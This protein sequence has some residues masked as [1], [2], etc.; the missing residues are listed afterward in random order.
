M[1]MSIL[2][3]SK[4]RHSMLGLVLLF[5]IA[6][7]TTPDELELLDK[8]FTAYERALRWQDYDLIISFHKNER[9]KLTVEKRKY[10]KRF[11]VTGYNVV[12]S[13]VEPGNTKANQV[14]EIKYYDENYATVR[15]LTISNKWEYDEN[16][17]HW[18]LTNDLP[19]FK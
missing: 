9:E 14:I 11:R 16:I 17:K 18:Q 7:A 4:I 1:P 3:L 5:P 8:S 6:C 12:Y 13:S 19:D 2:A 15:D 10:L